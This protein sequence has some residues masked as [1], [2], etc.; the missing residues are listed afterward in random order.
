M[1][2]SEHEKGNEFPRLLKLDSVRSAIKILK[3]LDADLHDLQ[4]QMEAAYELCKGFNML[5]LLGH[6]ASSK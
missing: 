3:K 5:K 6:L 4:A 1:A 2:K